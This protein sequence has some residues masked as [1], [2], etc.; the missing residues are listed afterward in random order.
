VLLQK[1]GEV[2][3]V[4]NIES[5]RPIYIQLVE[6]IKYQ[7]IAGEYK[8]GDRV[9]SVRELAATAAVNPNTM[10]KALAELERVGL[11][12]TQRTSGRF[13]TDDIEMINT[14][15]KEIAFE[16][17]DNFIKNMSAI[18]IDKAEVLELFKARIEEM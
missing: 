5:D 14:L 12:Y 16:Q 13:I 15:K 18:G 17:I 6:H 10:Q 11:M 1:K 3:L 8:P 9:P 2:V 4:W 7:I